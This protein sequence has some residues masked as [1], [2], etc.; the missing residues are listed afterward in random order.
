MSAVND[1]KQALGEMWHHKL[2]TGLT[3]LGMVFGVGAVI[4]MLSIGEGAEREALKMIESMGLRNVVVEAR[5]ADGE[6]LKAIREHSVGL[7]LGD[8]RAAEQTLPFVTDWSA[9]KRVK[10]HALFSEF[11][12]SD[13]EVSGVTPNHFSLSN[14]SLAEG[15]FFT[16][17]DQRHYRQLAVLGGEAAASL[18]PNGDAIGKRVKVNH[19]WYQVVGVLSHGE[20]VKSK[21]DGV[22]LGGERNKVFIPLKTALKKM[23][24]APLEDELDFIKLELDDTVEAPLAAASIDHLFNRR[25]GGELDYKVVVPADLLAQY[26]QTQR[27]FNIVMA[28][29]A[30]ISLLVGGIGIMNIMLATVLER[31]G[32]IGLLRAL[33]ATKSDIARQFVTESLVIAACG[34]LIGIVAGIALSL[35]IGGYADWQVAWSPM[36]LLLSVGVCMV[37]GVGFGW[38]PARKAAALDPIIALQRD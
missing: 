1:V 2:R 3:L 13:G 21:I 22:K 9:A 8:V 30:G 34:G 25:H 19:L 23:A 17:D 28:C 6:A 31:T 16:E 36:S 24:F 35:I 12:R 33:G 29:V 7:S 38:Y 20:Q 27:I 4:A 37:I 14:F 10:V 18:F 32:E 26:Q 15:R 11:G 5:S